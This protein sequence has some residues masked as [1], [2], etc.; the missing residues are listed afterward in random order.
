M[1]V[2]LRHDRKGFL[3]SSMGV[4]AGQ[5]EVVIS[6]YAPTMRILLLAIVMAASAV[7]QKPPNIILFMVDDLGWLADNLALLAENEPESEPVR[8]ANWVGIRATEDF[9]GD[10]SVYKPVVLHHRPSGKLV[11]STHKDF[12]ESLFA[13][14]PSLREDLT[15]RKVMADL[16]DRGN[17]MAYAS[18]GVFRMLREAFAKAIETAPGPSE[19][20][21][22]SAGL[23]LFLPP[24]ARGEGS[25]TTN[26]PDGILTISNSSHSHKSN[27]LSFGFTGPL[28]M[29]MASIMPMMAFGQAFEEDVFIG[30]DAIEVEAVDDLLDEPPVVR[31]IPRNPKKPKEKFDK[32]GD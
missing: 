12:A 7:G 21:I 16:P 28:A 2:M 23:D 14:K 27:L 31:P 5:T 3:Q 18:P 24:N 13:P 25:V 4:A 1:A 17:A 10:F 6:G 26:L 8:E 19:A 9:P 29:G 11:V 30:E 32:E 22:A 20:A 15:F